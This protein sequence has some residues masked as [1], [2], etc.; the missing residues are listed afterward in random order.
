MDQVDQEYLK[1]MLQSSG[2]SEENPNADVKVK[3]DGTTYEEIL[4][5]KRVLISGS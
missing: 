4:V 5:S 1:E 2:S 3:D